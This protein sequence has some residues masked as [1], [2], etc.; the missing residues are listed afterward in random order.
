ME[1]SVCYETKGLTPIVS[2]LLAGLK[3]VKLNLCPRHLERFD[4]GHLGLDKIKEKVEIKESR[5]RCC[6]RLVDKD[7]G[8]C[9]RCGDQ[10]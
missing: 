3:P 9:S 5:A 4:C 7:S 2:N 1:C 10:Y 8:R 6:G